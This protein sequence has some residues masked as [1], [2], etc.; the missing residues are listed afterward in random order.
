METPISSFFTAK[1]D[2][3]LVKLLSLAGYSGKAATL[4]V[5]DLQ[6]SF[7]WTA[8]RICLAVDSLLKGW[9]LGTFVLWKVDSTKAGP[10]IARRAFW[11][12][13]NPENDD[14][15][16]PC[17]DV[18]WSPNR[19]T[20][21]QLVLDGQQRIQSFLIAFAESG[22]FCW[23]EDRWMYWYKSNRWGKKHDRKSNPS[24][25]AR[26]Y[27]NLGA[28]ARELTSN[29]ERG[30]LA[31]Y[32]VAS[33]HEK[34]A[35]P[36]VWVR[37]RPDFKPAYNNFPLR[38]LSEWRGT[39]IV[40]LSV[41]WQWAG[42]AFDDTIVARNLLEQNVAE[43]RIADLLALTQHLLKGLTAVRNKEVAYIELREKQE[44]EEDEAYNDAI[45]SVFTRL[46]TGGVELAPEDIAFAWIKRGWNSGATPGPSAQ[47][48]FHE[49]RKDLEKSYLAIT[50]DQLVRLAAAIWAVLKNDGHIVTQADLMN[51]GLTAK[52]SRELRENWEVASVSLKH[53]ADV[54]H[55]HKLL[56]GDHF[57]SVSPLLALSAWYAVAHRAV[58]ASTVG[59][60]AQLGK[61]KDALQ[62]NIERVVLCGQV[63]GYWQS[64]SVTQSIG[65]RLAA[66]AKNEGEV[67]GKLI[68][69]ME[70]MTLDISTRC[71]AQSRSIPQATNRSQVARYRQWLRLW[72]RL[73]PARARISETTLTAPGTGK[74]GRLEV[75][76]IIPVE[77][78]NRLV[79]QAGLS[80]TQLDSPIN[81]LGN[82]VLL[83]KSFNISKRDNCMRIFM[84][85]IQTDGDWQS[86]LDIPDV[87]ADPESVLPEDGNT[88]EQRI[89]RA[90]QE[91]EERVKREL[92]EYAS[93]ATL[94]K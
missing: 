41:L 24:V 27:V 3:T 10:T 68:A 91:R 15:Q 37:D 72:H 49:L 52:L 48:S 74:Q 19:E 34:N 53:I 64:S 79:H 56:L 82:C 83:N 20:F 35:L 57:Y 94:A 86:A 70:E 62:S 81:S 11:K 76:H 54:L 65:G 9:P 66:I 2:T 38:H 42:E 26:L 8:E 22:R 92:A 84:Q 7:V 60:T 25:P 67:V 90:I 14:Y 77:L 32:F 17:F 63:S 45:V 58:P 69:F 13:A 89:I 21:Y 39:P 18:N 78:W 46:N 80:E 87:L 28:L 4:L 31:N 1:T 75:D 12:E 43:E 36:L 29:A 85:R 23:H 73:T 40:P 93:G 61:V 71:A 51:G 6:R 5:P 33:H 30:V 50:N 59:G 88:R 16:R 44:E 55:E 47:Q